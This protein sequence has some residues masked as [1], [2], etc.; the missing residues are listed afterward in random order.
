MVDWL[1]LDRT[2]HARS[3]RSQSRDTKVEYHE[4]DESGARL[5][6]KD[7]RKKREWPTMPL[8]KKR[9][10]F[11]ED[12]DRSRGD[13]EEMTE[14]DREGGAEE[15]FEHEGHLDGLHHDGEDFDEDG[16]SSAFF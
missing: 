8:T 2:V 13:A 11:E 15:S 16:K 1:G 6:V 10:I 14:D 12:G 4:V 3:K 7:K 5:I 9:R